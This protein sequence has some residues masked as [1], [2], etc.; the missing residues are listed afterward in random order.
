MSIEH[1][2]IMNNAKVWNEATDASY[3]AW[4]GVL[5]PKFYGMYQTP[6]C[7]LDFSACHYY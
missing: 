3:Y 2:L 5:S 4:I 1:A 6:Q 7:G